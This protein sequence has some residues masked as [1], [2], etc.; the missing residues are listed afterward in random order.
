MGALAALGVVLAVLIV[1]RALVIEAWIRRVRRNP[2]TAV[3]P[4]VAPRM[5]GV[6][7]MGVIRGCIACAPLLG[8]LG[9]VSGIID[10]FRS[11]LAG[12][13]MADMSAGISRALLTTQYGLAIAVPA[14]LAECV[15]ARRFEHLLH[16]HRAV[17]EDAKEGA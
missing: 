1:E 7:R 8:L 14:L 10:T 17:A 3:D 5:S 2:D 4:R 13:Y 15:L 12:G 16:L 6:R 11:I 9:T